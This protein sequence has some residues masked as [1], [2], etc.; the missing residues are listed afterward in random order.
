MKITVL[1]V[2]LCCGVARADL[3]DNYER[4]EKKYGKPVKHNTLAEYQVESRFYEWKGFRVRVAFLDGRAHREEFKRLD[5]AA[6]SFADI[7]K[8]VPGPA[9]GGKW[10][11]EG[12]NFWKWAGGAGDAQYLASERQLNT[13]TGDWRRVIKEWTE[14]PRSE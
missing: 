9:F 7:E 14:R 10:K 4:L 3:L 8:C 5:G 11:K 1:A 13:F 6:M 12:A 2:A